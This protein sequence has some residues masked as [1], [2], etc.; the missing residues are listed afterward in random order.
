MATRM[1]GVELLIDVGGG[2]PIVSPYWI[3]LLYRD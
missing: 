2:A 3:H 1:T